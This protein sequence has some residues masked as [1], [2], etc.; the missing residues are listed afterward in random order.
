MERASLKKVPL[1]LI[2]TISLAAG[3]EKVADKIYNA[4]TTTKRLRLS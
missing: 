2:W 1:I 4:F 3:E